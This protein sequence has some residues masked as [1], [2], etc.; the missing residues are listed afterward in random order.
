MQE[1]TFKVKKKLDAGVVDADEIVDID[2]DI[3]PTT[4]R[5][6]VL[7][8]IKKQASQAIGVTHNKLNQISKNIATSYDSSENKF[9]KKS[10]NQIPAQDSKLLEGAISSI[11]GNSYVPTVRHQRGEMRLH[12]Y[13][14]KDISAKLTGV[15][16]ATENTGIASLLANKGGIGERAE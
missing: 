14:T 6:S 4:R 16:L 13:T 7:K 10:F 5:K 12:L 2:I 1:A 9:M 8:T 11:L 3:D 15:W